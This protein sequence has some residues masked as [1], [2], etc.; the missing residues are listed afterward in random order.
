MNTQNISIDNDSIFAYI[1]TSNV[2]PNLEEIVKQAQDENPDIQPL[3]LR[4]INV[5]RIIDD[6]NAHGI[7]TIDVLD[8]KLHEHKEEILL[9]FNNYDRGAIAARHVFTPIYLL[10]EII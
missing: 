4:P 8:Q 2:I 10:L 6:L 3:G 9:A 5:E 1:H 7:T